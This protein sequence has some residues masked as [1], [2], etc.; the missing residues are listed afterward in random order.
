MNISSQPESYCTLKISNIISFIWQST[1]EYL[2]QDIY[3][4]ETLSKNNFKVRKHTVRGFGSRIFEMSD[5][6][7]GE[8]QDGHVKSASRICQHQAISTGYK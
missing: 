3:N 7:L 8:N 1:Y 4:F 6:A 2:E 5:L